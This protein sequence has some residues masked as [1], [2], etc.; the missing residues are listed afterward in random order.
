MTEKKI[1]IGLFGFGCVGQ[2]L[3]DVLNHSQGLR[4]NIKK[5]C[6]KDRDKK[7][8]IDLSY[9]TF[10]KNDI[11]D[12]N[13]VDVVVEL[14]DNAHDAL[15]I[16]TTA[17]KKGMNV[18]T[19]NKK[20][21]ADNFDL[22]FKL[23]QKS[24]VALIYEGAVGGSIPII[25]NLEE[26]YDNEL[27][28]SVRGLLNGSCNYILS[29]MELDKMGYAEALQKAQQNGFAETDPWLDVAG[30][31]T[32]N[33]LCLLTAHAF[34]VI[35]KPE[36]VLTLGIQNISDDDMLYAR[37]K[38]FRIKLVATA[39]KAGEKLNVFAMPC[40]VEK[41]NEFY[42]VMYENNAVEVEGAFSDKQYFVGKGAGSYP[43]GSAVLSDISALTYQYRYGYRKLKKMQQQLGD[44]LNAVH[45]LDNNISQRVYIR[46]TNKLELNG[47]EIQE[48]EED[49][50]S[51]K[52]NYLIA[53]V[54][55]QSLF[56][57]K[58]DKNQK[59]FI[60]AVP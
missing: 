51:R 36:Q 13:D 59:M 29:C 12:R 27:L 46:Y 6:V 57:L 39:R 56:H 42:N 16:V 25:R 41:N 3:Y 32:L 31:D 15:Q 19:A 2:G 8:K 58:D 53:K 1:S 26:Y 54:S 18:V 48:V 14:I 24:G 21:L 28:S 44:N 60:C 20:M 45:L 43:T 7:R 30:F 10:D 52:I 17:M 49:Y 5:I 47:I 33:K 35:L 9:F 50:Q 23:Q 40:F 37:E 22:L 38:G 4:A 11:L 55:L 34:G